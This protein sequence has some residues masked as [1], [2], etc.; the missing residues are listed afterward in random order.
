MLD[1]FNKNKIKSLELRLSCAKTE[2]DIAKSH[3]QEY[4]DALVKYTKSRDAANLYIANLNN[5][6]SK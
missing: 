4:Y 6:E 1:L 5:K 3:S 2:L